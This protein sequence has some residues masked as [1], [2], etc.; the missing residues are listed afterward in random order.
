M[1]KIHMEDIRLCNNAGITFPVCAVGNG[2]LD[3]DK[4]HWEITHNFQLV[5]CKKCL[6][7]FH[8]RYP[9]ARGK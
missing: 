9:W 7:A 8:K 1:P 5:T 6:K 4:S 3:C 2:P